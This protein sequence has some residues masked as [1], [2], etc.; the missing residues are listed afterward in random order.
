MRESRPQA[1]RMRRIMQTE[2]FIPGKDASLESTIDTMQRKLAARGF[3]LDE[4]SW[5]N[6]I[7]RAHV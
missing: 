4:S 7:G 1:D 2:S 3:E 5:L 6:Q